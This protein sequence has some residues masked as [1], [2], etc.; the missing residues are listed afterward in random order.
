MIDQFQ[1]DNSNSV[2]RD[3]E[4]GKSLTQS[5]RRELPQIEIVQPTPTMQQMSMA[6]LPG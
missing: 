6:P 3:I 5:P 1:Q 2:D 4:A